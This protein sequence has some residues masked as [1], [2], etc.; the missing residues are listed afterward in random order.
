[1]CVV[2]FITEPGLIRRILDHF[3]AEEGRAQPPSQPV[4]TPAWD[5]P[6]VGRM[7]PHPDGERRPRLIGAENPG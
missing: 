5:G 1:M 7:L 3:A 4:Q 2:S 6:P